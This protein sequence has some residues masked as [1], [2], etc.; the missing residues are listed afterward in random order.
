MHAKETQIGEKLRCPDCFTQVEIKA[1]KVGPPPAKKKT[2]D[3]LEEFQLSEPGNRPA[4]KP[5][6]EARG[7][8]EELKLL[9]PDKPPR[10][11]PSPPGA[12]STPVRSS[13]TV[14]PMLNEHLLPGPIAGPL[15]KHPATAVAQVEDDLDDQEVVLSAP[16]ER[17]EVRSEVKV[18]NV[19]PPPRDERKE[20]TWNDDEWGFVSDPRAMGAWKKSPFYV[21]IFSIFVDPQ[22]LLRVAAYS[23]GLSVVLALLARAAALAD[24]ANSQ[25]LT[26]IFTFL[27]S[28]ILGFLV[29]ISF[30]PVLVA[31]AADTANGDDKVQ[32]WPDWNVG[33]WILSACYVPVAG[34]LAAMPGVLM[35]CLFFAVGPEARW[36]APFP[37]LVTFLALFP[38]LFSSIL[39]ENS[40]F[41]LISGKVIRSFRSHGDGWVTFYILSFFVFLFACLGIAMAEGGVLLGGMG[42]FLTSFS[43]AVLFVL[44]LVLYIRLLGRL[45][46]YTQTVR[47]KEEFE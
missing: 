22:I 40:L 21:G 11:E 7:E 37:P 29:L 6:V 31:I 33:E 18:P 10:K 3:E 2:L 8:Y 42:L 45:M 12:T 1:P 15:P 16:V 25:T 13:E 23:I 30:S 24:P 14:D 26:A 34:I 35:A 36:F 27:T 19:P 38:V 28:G 20:P 46:W 39:T 5:M 4:Y 47:K 41:Y 32:S 9:D 44:L 17:I 43:S